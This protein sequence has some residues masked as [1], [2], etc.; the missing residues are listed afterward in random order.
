MDWNRIEGNWKAKRMLRLGSTHCR[1]RG[2]DG[3]QWHSARRD[4][5]QMLHR[6]QAES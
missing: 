1:K 6:S 5:L 4:P 2:E 3:P